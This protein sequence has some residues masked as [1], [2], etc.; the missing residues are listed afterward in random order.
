VGRSRARELADTPGGSTEH[1]YAGDSQGHGL[2]R[3]DVSVNP[4]SVTRVGGFLRPGDFTGNANAELFEFNDLSQLNQMD[5]AD[6]GVKV[7]YD[8]GIS[9]GLGGGGAVALAYWGDRYWIFNAAG[10]NHST[11]TQFDIHTK[12]ATPWIADVGFRVTGAG[13]STCAPT[14]YP[15]VK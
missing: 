3:W 11:V 7:T 9:S 6:G 10:N 8:P 12:T 4:P 13:V 14:V 2:Y 15:P 1:L 5:M